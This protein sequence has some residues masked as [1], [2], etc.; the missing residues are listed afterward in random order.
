M[1]KCCVGS[2]RS[3]PSEKHLSTGGEF[4]RGILERKWYR[5]GIE[6]D[7]SV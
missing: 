3:G 6:P 2:S 4:E 1:Y 5:E 7:T